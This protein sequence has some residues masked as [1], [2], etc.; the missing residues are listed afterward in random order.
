MSAI[1]PAPCRS[2]RRTRPA[3]DTPAVVRRHRAERIPPAR[4]HDSAAGSN[5]SQG[6]GRRCRGHRLRRLRQRDRRGRGRTSSPTHRRARLRTGAVVSATDGTM[7]AISQRVLVP[8]TADVVT[9]GK[10]GLLAC[11][12]ASW[13]GPLP[14]ARAMAGVTAER[15]ADSRTLRCL[16]GMNA[17]PGMRE[18]CDGA[19]PAIGGNMP[20]NEVGPFG[21]RKRRVARCR[22]LKVPRVTTA[23][24]SPDRESEPGIPRC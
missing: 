23:M 17:A 21:L 14:T 8:S 7:A 9:L 15:A 24:S 4:W 1:S 18:P 13:L 22:H 12:A 16:S 20:H 2:R 19:A 5:D 10:D 3:E 11:P 6:D